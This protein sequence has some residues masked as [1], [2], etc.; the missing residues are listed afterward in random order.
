MLLQEILDNNLV[1]GCFRKLADQRN[2]GRGI[3]DL[4]GQQ[5]INHWDK[6]A[7]EG[8]TLKL[9]GQGNMCG[10]RQQKL[11]KRNNGWWD[12]MGGG[13]LEES[14]NPTWIL[15]CCGDANSK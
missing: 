4:E 12:I 14:S 13:I 2:R 7:V 8:C 9:K 3:Q 1:V 5:L 11:H 15:W 10:I 6:N